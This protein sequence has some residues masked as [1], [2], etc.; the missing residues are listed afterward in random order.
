MNKLR[1]LRYAGLA[2]HSA[3][4]RVE[5]GALSTDW[6][7][8]RGLELLGVLNIRPG[9]RVLDLGCASGELTNKL[10]AFVGARGRVVGIDPNR[11]RI[12]SARRRF[13]DAVNL[14]FVEGTIDCVVDFE[15]FD[16]VFSN[17][18]MNWISDHAHGLD[19]IFQS[20]K[21][22]GRLGFLLARSPPI[23]LQRLSN[24]MAGKPVDLNAV[25][26][27]HFQ[28]GSD[29]ASLCQE[30]GFCNV[31]IDEYVAYNQHPSLEHMVHW[32]NA[33][34]SKRF[35]AYLKEW[36]QETDFYRHVAAELGIDLEG[37]VKFPENIIRVV[38]EKR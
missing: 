32:W 27:W 3:P 9:H 24:L 15:R 18:V 1:S 38:A 16:R 6:Q 11:E 19:K 34:T 21:S 25:M 35:S 8:K 29:W 28:S 14:T 17:F 13:G 4:K 12:A 7:A 20:I 30:A 10:A 31:R 33:T 26:N 23:V 2:R 37:P 5:Y 22:T 36:K